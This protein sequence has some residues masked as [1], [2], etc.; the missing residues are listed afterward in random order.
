MTQTTNLQTAYEHSRLNRRFMGAGADCR[1]FHCL[2]AFSAE[3]INHWVDNGETALCPKCSVDAVLSGRSDCLSEGLIAALRAAYF[4]GP[5]K[6]YTA[7]E[8]RAAVNAEHPAF[9]AMASDT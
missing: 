8:W 2:H 7:G 4:D 5:S 1:C 9:G 3:Q 6:K